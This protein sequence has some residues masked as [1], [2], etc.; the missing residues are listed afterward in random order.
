[1]KRPETVPAEATW[2]A[3]DSEWVLGPKNAAGDYHGEVHYWRPDGTLVSIA[4][5]VDGKPDGECRR[6]HE[7]GEVSQIAN[8]EGGDLHGNRTWLACDEPT[9]EKM[10]SPGMSTDIR[11]AE[12]RYVR[13][14]PQKFRFFLGD[15]T[16]VELDGTPLVKRPD[17]VPNGAMLNG[18]KGYW[19]AGVW[20]A[21]GQKDG[22]MTLYHLDGRL[23]SIQTYSADVL[24]GPLAVFYSDGSVRTR[25]HHVDGAVSGRFEYFYRGGGISRRGELCDGSWSGPLEDFDRDGSVI[26]SVRIE[27]PAP[28]AEVAVLTTGERALIELLD[29]GDGVEELISEPL[30]GAAVAELIAI[31]W[32]GDDDRNAAR[33]RAARAATK[34]FAKSDEALATRL[35]AVGLDRAPRLITG[36]RLERLREAMADVAAIDSAALDAAFAAEGGV[37]ALAALAA[38]GRRALEFLRG[39]IS[40]ERRLAIDWLGLTELPPEVRY[41]PDLFEIEA[42]HN[43]LRALPAEI[44]DVAL[45]RKLRLSNNRIETLPPELTRLRDLASLHL[46]D[47]HLEALPEVLLELSELEILNLSDNQLDRI[48]DAFGDLCRLDTLWLSDNPLQTLPGSFARLENLTFLHLGAAPWSEPPACIWELASLETL[49]LASRDLTRI[50]PDVARLENLKELHVWYSALES[51]PDELFEMTQLTELRIRDNP[52]PDGTVDRLREALPDCTI[53]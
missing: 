25:R 35:A 41:M 31:G 34:T 45:L 32:G 33:A 28:P 53:Y 4:T 48:P 5:L 30:S 11:R 50:P 18:P 9:T 49:W 44:A 39:R 43:K 2:C 46:A 15:G 6:F 23:L 17:G 37:G 22:E 1:M 13:G 12:V 14:R 51:V 21:E 19:M 52:L 10:H 42:G 47:N 26:R 3:E 7:S 36:D 29:D 16:E 38:G 8:Y 24:D 20:N 40:G 27:P